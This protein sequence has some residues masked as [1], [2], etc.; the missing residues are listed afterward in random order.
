VEFAWNPAKA[1]ENIRVHGIDFADAVGVFDNPYLPR[2]DPD[3]EGEQKFVALG[4]DGLG[5]LLVVAYPYREDN[6]RII[7]ARKATKKEGREYA[8][9]IRFQ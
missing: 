6:I 2:D 3:A 8:Q 7:S 4:I 9:R 1:R 5:R